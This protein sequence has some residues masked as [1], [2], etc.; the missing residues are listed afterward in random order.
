MKYDLKTVIKQ[1]E[2]QKNSILEGWMLENSYKLKANPNV[3]KKGND[4]EKRK[5]DVTLDFT[6]GQTSPYK[7]GIKHLRARC[8]N[9]IEMQG[10]QN[11]QT[12]WL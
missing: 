6:D 2:F 9:S 3:P 10:K 8:I 1:A 4:R 5:V 11:M 12:H 7:K